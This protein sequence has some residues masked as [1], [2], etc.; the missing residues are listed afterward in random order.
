MKPGDVKKG[1]SGLYNWGNPTDLKHM[2]EEQGDIPDSEEDVEYTEYAHAQTPSPTKSTFISHEPEYWVFDTLEVKVETRTKV[3]EVLTQQSYAVFVD[4]VK[5]LRRPKLHSVIFAR[6]LQVSLDKPDS[7]REIIWGLIELL[8]SAKIFTQK[9]IR[10][11]FDKIYSQV[12]DI[13]V[14]V[15]NGPEVVLDFLVRSIIG[16][17]IPSS[18]ILRI[19]LS[20]YNLGS[21]SYVLREIKEKNQV[22]GDLVETLQ[23]AKLLIIDIL[24][25]YFATGVNEGVKDYL[26]RDLNILY[27]PF[28]IRKAIE[29]AIE[30][31]NREKELCSRLLGEISGICQPNTFV[32]AFDDTL[33]NI[34]ETSIDVPSAPELIAKFIARAMADDCLPANYIIDSELSTIEE[35]SIELTVLLQAQRLINHREAYTTLQSVW[36]PQ[37]ENLNDYQRQFDTIIREFLDSKDHRNAKE[38]LK[39]LCCPHYMHEFVRKSIKLVMDKSEQDQE[40]VLQL[41][42]A[43]KR[44]GVILETQVQQG[45]E[46]IEQNL[47]DLRLDV[48]KADEILGKFKSQLQ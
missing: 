28:V 34:R 20:F 10:R 6:I 18:V 47:G 33:R 5:Q 38:C 36:G 19:P 12:S 27:G 40:E 45:I 48:P 37:V 31:D 17:L 22:L 8:H 41:I 7:D 43:L 9:E 44:E 42:L 15:P 14:D 16:G 29:L 46:R 4:W 1:G 32:E 26:K 2:H 3:Q 13:V 30:R 21:G 39:E 11:G 24:K 25:E 23:E 35:N